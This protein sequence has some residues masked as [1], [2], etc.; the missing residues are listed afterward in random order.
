MKTTEIVGFK[1][2]EVGTTSSKKLRADGNAPCVVYGGSGEPIHF[3]APMYLFK[4]L[5]YSPNAFI[6][7]L[8]IEGTEMRCILK[9][10][11]YHPVSE[12]INHVDFLRITEDKPVTIDIPI[13]IVG[14]ST[15]VADGGKLFVKINKLKIKALAKDLPDFVDVSIAGLGLG[16]S[17]RVKNVVANN[18]EILTRPQVT[19]A[20]VTIPRALKAAGIKG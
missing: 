7:N 20:S 14:S 4:D 17:V 10:A 13:K 15:G 3:Y 16:K 5:L 1:R 2:T 18:F 8:N 6:V 19:I 12:V 9:D 11:S